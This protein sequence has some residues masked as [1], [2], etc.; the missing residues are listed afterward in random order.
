MSSIKVEFMECTWFVEL[1]ED[2]VLDS[3]R[4]LKTFED[5]HQSC[6]SALSFTQQNNYDDLCHINK[7]EY[8]DVISL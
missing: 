6:K 1:S 4:E 8:Y 7:K 2:N 3:D 5:C